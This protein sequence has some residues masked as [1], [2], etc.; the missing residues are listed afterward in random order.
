MAGFLHR[1]LGMKREFKAHGRAGAQ[2][3]SAHAGVGP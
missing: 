1:I 3:S 2:I